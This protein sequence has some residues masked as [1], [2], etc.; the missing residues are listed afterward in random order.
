M[1]QFSQRALAKRAGV[2]RYRIQHVEQMPDP[3]WIDTLGALAT[4]ERERVRER[5]ICG[6]QRAKAQGKRLGRRAA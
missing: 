4:F 1:R 6:L 3:V 5:V 2:S